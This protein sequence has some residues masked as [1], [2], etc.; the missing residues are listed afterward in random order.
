[1]LKSKEP[2]CAVINGGQPLRLELGQLGL[3][4]RT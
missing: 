4:K 2:I 3:K 1:M